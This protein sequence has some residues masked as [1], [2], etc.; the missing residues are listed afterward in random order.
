MDQSK[1]SNSNQA[2]VFDKKIHLDQ[3]LPISPAKIGFWA[4]KKDFHF[5]G[6]SA[7]LN[8]FDNTCLIVFFVVIY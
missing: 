2:T 1:I 7:I 3:M 4:Y 5:W 8:I 6:D